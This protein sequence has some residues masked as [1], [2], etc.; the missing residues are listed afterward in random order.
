MK[1]ILFLA[2]LSFASSVMVVPHDTNMTDLGTLEVNYSDSSVSSAS[3]ESVPLAH[4][5][6]HAH[7]NAHT[8]EDY[9]KY[10]H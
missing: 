2:F 8:H 7:A 10:S 9:S 3:V 1:T 6:A 5:H 4:A